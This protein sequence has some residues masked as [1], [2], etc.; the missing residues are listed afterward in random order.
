MTEC[1][2]RLWIDYVTLLEI[3]ERELSIKIFIFF[4]FILLQFSTHCDNFTDNMQCY[5]KDWDIFMF[6]AC[7]EWKYFLK[8]YFVT[9]TEV[10]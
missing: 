10:E 2:K 4:P 8:L 1:H 5:P 9:K 3:S 7:N 6:T